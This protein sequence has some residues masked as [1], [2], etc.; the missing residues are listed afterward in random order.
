MTG[1]MKAFLESVERDVEAAFVYIPYGLAAA[2]VF[3][4]VMVLYNRQKYGRISFLIKSSLLIVYAVVV[5][6]LTLFS[7]RSGIVD[8]VDLTFF[9]LLEE[10]SDYEIQLAENVLLF[11]PA[12]VL[13]PWMWKR[14]RGWKCSLVFG[15]VLSLLIETT[16][17]L[18]GRG[19][20]QIDDL[21]TNVA[22]MMAGYGIGWIV[23][24]LWK[25]VYKLHIQ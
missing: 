5:G 8:R 3:L 25:R 22:G 18:T 7:R 17:L 13:C 24:K 12:G 20:F 21:L 2:A 1:F 14:I 6:Y 10:S 19:L 4:C 9:S 15:F 16:Q 23:K 11:V